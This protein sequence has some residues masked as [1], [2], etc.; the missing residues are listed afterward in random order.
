MAEQCNSRGVPGEIDLNVLPTLEATNEVDDIT[1]K[2]NTHVSQKKTSQMSKV[3]RIWQQ[4][5]ENEVL[6]NTNVFSKKALNCGRKRHQID[7]NQFQN[8]P[9]RRRT[10]L[11]SLSATTNLSVTTLFRRLKEGSIRRHSN[12]IKPLLNVENMKARIRFCLSMIEHG[13]NPNCLRFVTMENIIHVDEKWFYKTKQ[14]EKYYLL[15]DEDK[16]LRTL[17]RPRFDESGNEL[18]S[19]KIGVFPFINKEP[20]RRSSKNRSAGTMETK[21]INS[22]NKEIY[23]SYIVEKLLLAI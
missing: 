8:I 13:N 22:I 4:G 23:Q 6:D 5:K 9:L 10:T 14:S 2:V 16:P 7:V 18:F 19:E 20:A 15:L 3:Q 1:E 12:S 17:T 21:T 11:R